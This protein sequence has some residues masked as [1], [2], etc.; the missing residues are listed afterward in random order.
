MMFSYKLPYAAL[1]LK[2][3]QELRLRVAGADCAQAL[4]Q[5]RTRRKSLQKTWCGVMVPE[6]RM[7]V[8]LPSHRLSIP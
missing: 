5:V 8:H 1:N 3:L 2:Q 7:V 6:R 4:T